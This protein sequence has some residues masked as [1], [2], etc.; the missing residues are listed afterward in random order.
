MN[1]ISKPIKTS[2]R[3]LTFNKSFTISILIHIFLIFGITFLAFS[4]QTESNN[5]QIINVKFA[6]SDKDIIGEKSP[7]LKEELNTLSNESKINPL[8]S[9]YSYE[10]VKIKKLDANSVLKNEEA[11]YL[12]L[13]QRKVETLGN[14][15]ILNI[16]K[17]GLEGS[18]QILVTIDSSGNLIDTKILISSGNNKIDKIALEILKK[19]SPFEPFNSEMLKNYN[20]LE[21]VRDWNFLKRV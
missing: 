2:K 13:W 21:I 3:A 20:V 16:D 10:A 7:S 4:N 5:I 19:A 15:Y 1:S 18:V 12:N 11:Y 8:S 14:D 9:E 17:K 6:N